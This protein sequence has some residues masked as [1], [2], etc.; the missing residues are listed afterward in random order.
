MLEYNLIRFQFY[1]K[2][3]CERVSGEIICILQFGNQLI[4]LCGEKGLR[5]WPWR[6]RLT[7]TF[8]LL[9][10]VLLKPYTLLNRLNYNL[11]CLK[12]HSEMT[13]F[14]LLKWILLSQILYFR[15]HLF[16]FE[17]FWILILTQ[18]CLTKIKE[19][20][21]SQ[22]IFALVES[23]IVFQTRIFFNGTKYIRWGKVWLRIL[24]LLN[25]I[26]FVYMSIS[27]QFLSNTVLFSLFLVCD[28][29]LYLVGS[30]YLPNSSQTE[31]K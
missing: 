22:S 8:F 25:F 20:E 2:W 27:T 1:Q 24:I 15:E 23:N 17:L 26:V 13:P 28:V 18:T 12:L 21:T 11:N 6:F 9:S 10:W 4:Q 7:L 31:L 3:G 29:V 16:L 19:K 30:K 5:T 14:S